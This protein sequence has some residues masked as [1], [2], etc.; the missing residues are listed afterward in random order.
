MNGDGNL[1]TTKDA[2]DSH[3]LDA[4]LEKGKLKSSKVRFTG[5]AQPIPNKPIPSAP[6]PTTVKLP[7]LPP[8]ID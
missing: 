1:E 5:D 6:L 4:M 8:D 2:L 3:V 7:E